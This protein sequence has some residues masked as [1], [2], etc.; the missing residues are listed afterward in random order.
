METIENDHFGSIWALYTL[1][2]W[3]YVGVLEYTGIKLQV[4]DFLS[5]YN[6]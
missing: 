3:I 1:N 6:G 2:K 4:Y 5:I